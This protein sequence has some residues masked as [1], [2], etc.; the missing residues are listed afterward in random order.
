M[1]VYSRYLRVI[2]IFPPF[3]DRTFNLESAT[4]DHLGA[5]TNSP[6]L[7]PEI[8]TYNT[9]ITNRGPAG[10]LWKTSAK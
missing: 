5:R 3:R 7:P 2:G 10:K 8:Q 6:F 4:C 1:A 9:Q